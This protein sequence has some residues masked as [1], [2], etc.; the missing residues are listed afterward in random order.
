MKIKTKIKKIK[1]MKWLMDRSM[2]MDD[3]YIMLDRC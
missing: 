3:G 1:W 2:M